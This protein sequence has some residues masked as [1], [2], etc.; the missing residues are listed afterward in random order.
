MKTSIMLSKTQCAMSSW[1]QR[2]NGR[3]AP[4]GGWT[5]E[6]NRTDLRAAPK[7]SRGCEGNKPGWAHAD[8][9]TALR[10]GASTERKQDMA[11]LAV[12]QAVA[13]YKQAYE[14]GQLAEA[15]HYLRQALAITRQEGV[16]GGP[17][18]KS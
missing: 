7:A 15:E 10:R 17:R 14:Q 11:D 3:N 1:V 9:A 4:D 12:E 16:T 2:K 18:R 8:A 5:L 6:R 13:L